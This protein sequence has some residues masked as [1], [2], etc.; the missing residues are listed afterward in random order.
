MLLKQSFICPFCF[1]EH[2][3]SEIQFRCMNKRCIDV[4]DVELTRYENGDITIPKKGK[5][6]FTVKNAGMSIPKS[7][8][9]E[10]CGSTTYTII[11]PSCHNKL[12]E[13][14]LRGTD[15]IISVVGS[16]DTGKSHF[17]AVIINVAHLLIR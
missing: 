8:V 13:S 14:T 12:P 16:R 17:V 2:K 4:P 1:E 11:C 7:A 5:P 15:M 10:K 9:C 6:T 3:L